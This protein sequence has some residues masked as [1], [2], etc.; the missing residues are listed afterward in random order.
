MIGTACYIYGPAGLL[1]KRTIIDSESTTFYYHSDL[2]G[3]TRLVTDSNK[4]IVSAVTY[5][6]FGEPS[7]KEGSEHYL[8]TGKEKNETGLYYYGARHYDP[9]LG[10]FLTRDPYNGKLVKP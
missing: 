3:S 9:D 1:V 4:N 7:L 5:H 8:F 2:L 6:P 10:R